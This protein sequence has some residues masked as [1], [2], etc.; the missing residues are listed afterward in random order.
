MPPVRDIRFDLVSY[1]YLIQF[2]ALIDVNLAFFSIRILD[3]IR[4][5]IHLH[6]RAFDRV[7]SEALPQRRFGLFVRH[8][9]CGSNDPGAIAPVLKAAHATGG[10]QAV[11]R[12]VEGGDRATPEQVMEV[13][14]LADD[15]AKSRIAEWEK[16]KAGGL[17][18]FERVLRKSVRQPVAPSRT[19]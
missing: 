16:L 18:D 13:Y 9:I 10:L 17:A 7:F 3:R 8:R 5:A 4:F 12:V 19:I 14:R 2:R 11:L 15:A 6:Q 1:H